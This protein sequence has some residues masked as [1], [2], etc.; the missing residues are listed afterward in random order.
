MLRLL[1]T[2]L[3]PKEWGPQ[4]SETKLWSPCCEEPEV[5]CDHPSSHALFDP[6]KE[7]GPLHKKRGQNVGFTGFIK[8]KAISTPTARFRS[9]PSYS[10]HQPSWWCA[11][12]STGLFSEVCM[13][14]ISLLELLTQMGSAVSH[15]HGY[16]GRDCHS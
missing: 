13:F 1:R 14:P 11:A 10:S 16:S 15:E 4:N 6:R 2:E 7:A 12:S 9:Q 5:P 8:P 3:K